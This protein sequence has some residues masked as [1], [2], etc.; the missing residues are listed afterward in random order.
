MILIMPYF[1]ITMGPT[2]SGKSTLIL[3][4][5][6]ALGFD[7]IPIYKTNLVDDLVEA[8]ENYAKDVWEIVDGIDEDC[9]HSEACLENAFT[10]PSKATYKKFS[11]AYFGSREKYNEQNDKMLLADVA[12]GKHHIIFETTGRY[13]PKWLFQG[14]F[15]NTPNFLN[16]TI[17]VSYTVVGLEHLIKRNKSRAYNAILQ[18]KKTRKIGFRL[19][20]VSCK[21][22]KL[23]ADA[24]YKNINDVVAKC[25]RKDYD[26]GYC[27]NRRVDRMLVFDNNSNMSLIYGTEM[28]GDVFDETQLPYDFDEECPRESLSSR[29][30]KSRKSRKSK[31]IK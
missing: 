4:S 15:K 28:H 29:K 23:L 13:F 7:T 9:N 1:I 8:D 5:F 31:G 10:N 14:F 12:E 3:E 24:I 18:L 17:V 20:D 16:Y 2:G 22:Y 21:N 27:G 11:D 25:V 6:K 19:P 26:K 30:G